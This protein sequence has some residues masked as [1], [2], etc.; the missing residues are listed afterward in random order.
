MAVGRLTHD[1]LAG[2]VWSFLGGG[3]RGIGQLVI[4]AIFARVLTVQDFG[5]VT[6]VV[7]VVGLASN[8]ASFGIAP[9]VVQLPGLRAAHVRVAFT[10]SFLVGLVLVG[11]LWSIAPGL[12]WYFRLAGLPPLLRALAWLC[13]LQ[14]VAAV[15]EALLQRAMRFRTLAGVDTAACLGAF[16]TTGVALALAGFGVWA[17]VWAYLAQ[18]AVRAA[19]LLALQ[20]RPM[21]FAPLLER[22]PF[23][24]LAWF[25]GGFVIAKLLNYLATEGDNVVVGRGMGAEAVGLYGRAY[26]LMAMPAMFIGEILDKV[27]YPGMARVQHD[28]ERLGVAY[29]RAVGLIALIVLPVSAVLV[30]TAPEVVRLLLGPKW[31]GVVAPF[32]IFAAGMLLRTSYKIS[33]AMVRAKGAVYRRAWRQ[34]VYALC[35]LAAAWIGQRWGLSGVALG[36]TGAIAVNYVLMAHLSL[37]LTR[38]SWMAFW[39]A[40]LPGLCL[41]G[42]VGIESVAVVGALRNWGT[43]PALTVA[44]AGVLVLVSLPL[45]LWWAPDPFLGR[46]GSWMMR[47]L[48][49]YLP[50]RFGSAG[51]VRRLCAR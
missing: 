5:I 45:L 20:A 1:T 40:H 25:G 23:R 4:L 31:T 7:V 9:A 6:V 2:L 11:L 12:G 26:Q 17:L 21:P 32:Q 3:A 27:L 41:G 8:I 28:V 51:W 14:G 15:A 22:G 48:A 47:A 39:R 10:A 29:T 19:L 44:G 38:L 37:N 33:D 49:P 13:P 30:V 16:G 34:A 18:A 36:V 46:D 35:V 43:P 42:V 50:A 24:D